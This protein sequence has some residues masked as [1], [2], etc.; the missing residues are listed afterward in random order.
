MQNNERRLQWC[1]KQSK[2][3][4]MVKPSENLVKAYLQKSRNAVKSM[5]VNAQAGLVEWAVSTSYYAK[6]FA[7]YSLLTKIGIKCEIHDCTIIL[8]EYLFGDII[9]KEML[10]DLRNSKENRVEAQYYTQEINVDIKEVATKTK[11][12][13]LEIEKIIDGLNAENTSK[14]QSRL[15]ILAQK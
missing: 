4:R 10:T 13:V 15:H 5:E 6:Y 12:F 1:L 14:L 9:T 8:F 3:I 2:G 7:V 11:Q